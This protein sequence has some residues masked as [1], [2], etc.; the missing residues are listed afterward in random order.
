M[1]ALRTLKLASTTHT[2]TRRHIT[3]DQNFQQRRCRN[4]TY[5]K[6]KCLRSHS[7]NQA[8][9][10]WCYLLFTLS[11]VYISGLVSVICATVPSTY[12]STFNYYKIKF[13]FGCLTHPQ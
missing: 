5:L 12:H 6:F 1:K 3:E 10:M 11:S 8:T 7:Y 13:L 2:A 9:C 4:I